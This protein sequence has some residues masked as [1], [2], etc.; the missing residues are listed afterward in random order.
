MAAL[1][2]KER[3][4]S[5]GVQSDSERKIRKALEKNLSKKHAKKVF[6]DTEVKF[7]HLESI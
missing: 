2:E 6:Y 1:V 5:P 7:S 4:F 3:L